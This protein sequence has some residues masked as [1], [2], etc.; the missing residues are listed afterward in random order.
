MNSDGSEPA[1]IGIDW[2][3]SS[4]RAFL[5]GRD[6]AVLDRLS[7][8][9]G[10]MHVPDRDFEAVFIRLVGPWLSKKPLPILASGMI[11]SRN[12]WVETPYEQLPLG[13][14]G[15]A[16]SLVAHE[17]S[18]GARLHFVTGAT[19]LH[20][21]GPDVMRGEETQIVG[22]A[23][24]GLSDG[25]FVMPGTHSKWVIVES[26]RIA[27]YATYMTG[28]VF[29][30]LREHTILGT[31]MQEGPFSEEGFDRGIAA[32]LKSK[33]RLLH[34]LFHV[35][36]LPLMGQMEP[37]MVADYLSGMLIGSEIAAEL[38]N[39]DGVAE[40]TIVG[41][42][43]LANRYERG[44]AQAR[45]ASLRAPDDIV[46]IGHFVIAKAAGLIS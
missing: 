11:T 36:T 31:L 13:A 16:R 26:G 12:G 28:E 29:A 3:T 8:P 7:S 27:D 32:G 5:I 9:E 39:G 21:S 2:G 30:A 25:L 40:V 19:A 14:Q 38:E 6:G 17:T 20:D 37:S 15:L 44:L 10:I 1:L 22:A 45:V 41:R 18:A 23:A 34:A 43:D 46:A 35:R 4:L 24:M 33:S 42:S